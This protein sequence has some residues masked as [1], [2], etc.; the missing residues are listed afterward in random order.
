MLKVMVS[1]THIGSGRESIISRI[2]RDVNGQSPLTRQNLRQRETIQ[3]NSPNG[4]R[5]IPGQKDR[6]KSRV[7]PYPQPAFKGGQGN[8]NNT[9][10]AQPRS[11]VQSQSSVRIMIQNAEAGD[12]L[13]MPQYPAR[14]IAKSKQPGYGKPNQKEPKKNAERDTITK[15]TVMRNRIR[16]WL[17]NHNFR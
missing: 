14:A 12:R 2:D 8:P 13:K 16:V 7:N 11:S 4:G 5:V 3:R 15:D 6:Q 10:I 17:R 1:H 9:P